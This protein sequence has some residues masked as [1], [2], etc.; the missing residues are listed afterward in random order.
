MIEPIPF[1]ENVLLKDHCTFG[2]GGPAKYF[3]EIDSIFKMQNALLYCHEHQIPFM[4]LGKG[5]NCLF[6]DR[7]FNGAVI[8]NKI[9][10]FDELDDGVFHVGSGFSFALLGV[11]TAKAGWS[12]LEFASGIPATIGGAVFMNAGACNQE[13]SK[14]LISV[15]FVDAFGSL[16]VIG[17]ENLNFSYRKSPFQNTS[18]AV[19]GATFKLEKKEAARAHQIDILN[20]RIKT[21]PYTEKSAGCVF[22]NPTDQLLQK[23]DEKAY[24]GALIEQ[25]GLKDFSIGGASVSNVHANFL[26]NKNNSTSFDMLS[27]IKTIQTTVKE[28]TGY[29]LKNEVRF[30]PYEQKEKVLI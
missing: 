15:D 9:D 26:I 25:C 24:A 7:G 17:K 28:K 6:D 27:L 2:I 12:G 3:I 22:M 13:T 20:K 5:S 16:K 30:I 19:V 11:K 4:I 29:D 18:G 21:Q 1:K 10:F 14:A 23:G 8:L